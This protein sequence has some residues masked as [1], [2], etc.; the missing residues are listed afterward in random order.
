[1][2]TYTPAQIR[3]ILAERDLLREQVRQL[4]E[5]LVPRFSAPSS[6][7]MKPMEQAFLEAMRAAAPGVLTRDRAMLTLYRNRHEM[8]EPAVL[9]KHLCNLRKRIVQAGLPIKIESIKLTGWR[10]SAES[11]AAFDE[12]VSADRARWPVMGEAA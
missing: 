12:A 4:Q 3:S 1:M 6:W 9:D 5:I 7:E 2:D 11:C 10:L 8:P